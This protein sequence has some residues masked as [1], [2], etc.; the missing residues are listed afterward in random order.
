[1][2]HAIAALAAV[3]GLIHLIGVVRGIGP[4]PSP[5]ALAWL[6]ACL[7]LVAA[8]GLLLA[9]IG[10]GWPVLAAGVVVSQIL[11]VGDWTEARFGTIA[12][13]ILALAVIMAWADA[14]VQRATG[15][16][17]EALLAGVSTEPGPPV[18]AAEVAALPAPVAR[19]LTASGVIDRPRVRTVHLRQRGG[20]RTAPD[21][22]FMP[23]EAEQVF[24]T[25]EPGFVWSVRVT[26]GRLVPVAGRDQYLGG[27]G[28]MRIS[29]LS[30]IPL[31]DADGAEIDQGTLLRFLGE[32]VWF[33]SAALAPY[34]RWEP[35]D[36]QTA[37]A[38]M[39]YR[40]VTASALF[41]F[42]DRGR[43]VRL[44]AKRYQGGGPGARLED[45]SVI[46][47]AWTAM[48]GVIVPSK[49]VVSWRTAD[50]DF[51]YYRWEITDIEYDRAVRHAR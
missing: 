35:V 17:V 42:D 45:W 22:A 40:G 15:D 47:H 32:L 2:R 11:I 18:R 46:A 19:W 31:V 44:T 6:A 28:R 26:M 48:N 4:S 27:R 14:R 41:V 38:T 10:A 1:M 23:A 37:R 29:A 43:M 8:G 25:D 3:H 16:A 24:T 9:R 36:E 39:I 49:G 33:P 51:D 12:N 30:L 21:Q 7:L 34:I 20:L 5:R 50:G 13:L